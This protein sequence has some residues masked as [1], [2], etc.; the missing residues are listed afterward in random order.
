MTV[1]MCEVGKAGV[2]AGV[3]VRWSRENVSAQVAEE[4]ELLVVE[5]LRMGLSSA[6]YGGLVGRGVLVEV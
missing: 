1:E 6:H 5:R 2:G 3:D 4:V